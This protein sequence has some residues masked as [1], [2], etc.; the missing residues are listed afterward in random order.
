MNLDPFSKNGFGSGP[1][2]PSSRDEI[3]VKN[4]G[5]SLGRKGPAPEPLEPMEIPAAEPAPE[6]EKPK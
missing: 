4:K 6:P 5:G 1:G 2:K 3:F